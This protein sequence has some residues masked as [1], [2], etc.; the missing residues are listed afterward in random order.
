MHSVLIAVLVGAAGLAGQ[1][2]GV[3]PAR[4]PNGA[5][6]AKPAAKHIPDPSDKVA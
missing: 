1:M 5:I 3:P 6:A 4:R 2:M